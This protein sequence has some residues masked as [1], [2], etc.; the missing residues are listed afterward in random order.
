MICSKI[1]V[2]MLFLKDDFCNTYIYMSTYTRVYLKIYE[3]VCVCDTYD[4]ITKCY[5]I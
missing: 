5:L 2:N 1:K 3:Q 4:Y